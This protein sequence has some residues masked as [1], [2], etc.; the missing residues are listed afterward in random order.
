M[1]RM[2]GTNPMAR[3][4]QVLDVLQAKP[5]SRSQTS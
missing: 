3:N 5:F 4:A 2:V 1:V